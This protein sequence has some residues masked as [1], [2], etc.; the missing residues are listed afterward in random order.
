M[1]KEVKKKGIKVPDFGAGKDVKP[2]AKPVKESK[3]VVK[4]IA[5]PIVN[6]NK[7][8]ISSS[9]SSANEADKI[10][11]AIQKEL[12]QKKEGEKHQLLS[13]GKIPVQK[14]GDPIKTK[15]NAPNNRVQTGIEGL[16]KI[17]HGGFERNS[18]NIIGGGAG[19]GKSILCMQ[20]LMNGVKKYNEPGIY[21]TFE[22]DK[23]KML[24]HMK[25]F[26]WDLEKLESENKLAVIEYTPEQVGKL[27]EEGGGVIDNMIE[28]MGAKR[29]VID[30][31]TAFTM[32]H[33]DELAKI[34]ASLALFRLMQKWACT[35]LLTAESDPDPEKHKSTIMEFEVDGV[36]L[37][38]YL[39]KGD[40][41]ERAL[42][43][44]KL[45]GLAHSTKIFPMK[46]TDN[47]IVIFPEEGIF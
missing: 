44:L 37:L 36:I 12:K 41:R 17:M 26:G 16:D 8:K 1:A 33:R 46:I 38:Y 35:A 15:I 19:S 4:K 14:Q 23:K 40:T 10:K 7:N 13:N 21:I 3:P 25:Q 9:N 5:V 28:K 47:G 11:A 32:L 2:A 43:I 39:R 20:F 18:V 6:N 22:E 42:E 30:S 34:Q 27:L 31:L 45:R 24:K 29:I